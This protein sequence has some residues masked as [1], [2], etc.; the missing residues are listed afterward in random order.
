LFLYTISFATSLKEI[1]NFA[2]DILWRNTTIR[3]GEKLR[4]LVSSSE[5]PLIL[6]NLYLMNLIL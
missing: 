4:L 6:P 2:K 3:R 1:S 5:T